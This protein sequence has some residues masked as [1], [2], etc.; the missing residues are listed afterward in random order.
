[1]S[2]FSAHRSTALPQRRIADLPVSALGL[3]CMGMSYAYGAADHDESIATLNEAIDRGITML[4]TADIYGAGH[5]EQLLAEVLA[6]RRDEVVVA[7]K[8]G[9]LLDPDAAYPS[10]AKGTPDYVRTSV[11]SSL[12][13]L[14]ID[15]I[16]LYYLHR[17]DTT[18]PI[19]ETIGAMAEL[20]AAGKVRRLGISEPSAESLRRAAAV[21]PIAAVQSEWSIFSRDIERDVVPVAREIGATVV[22]YSPLGRGMLTGSAA[23]LDP[24]DGDFRTTLPRWQG[25]NLAA[26][27]ALVDRIVAIATDLRAT[28]AQVALAWLLARG[29]DVVPIPGTKR[30]RHLA[31]NLAAVDL[32]LPAGVL[33][34]LSSMSAAGDRYPDMGWVERDGTSR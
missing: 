6:T 17:V 4:D 2:V 11:E 31:D 7:T 29:S 33:D 21:H 5:N 13:R 27:R 32:D 24:Q 14:G 25:D 34:E 10:S 22:P 1:M 18:I 30:R 9:I 28:P 15:V 26:N 3:G 19:E 16:D 23:A 20:V 12:R 8:F